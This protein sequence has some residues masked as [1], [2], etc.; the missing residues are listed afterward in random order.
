MDEEARKI[1][2]GLADQVKVILVD[3][4]AHFITHLN[5]RDYEGAALCGAQFAHEFAYIVQAIAGEALARKVESGL[6]NLGGF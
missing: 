6:D 5:D 2:D 3:D 4:F 1:V